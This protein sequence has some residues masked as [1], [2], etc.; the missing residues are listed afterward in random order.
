MVLRPASDVSRRINAERLLLIAW[1]RAILLQFAHPMIAAAVAEH[2]SFR[3]STTAAAARLRHTVHAMLAL[4]FGSDAEREAALEAIQAIHRRVYGTMPHAS[5]LFPAG[6]RYSAEDTKLLIWVHATLVE[7]MVLVYEQLI[8]PLT[9]A[10]RDGYCDEA[11]DVAVALGASA[12][13]VPRS[14]PAVQQYLGR[15]YVSGEIAVGE[16]ASA[17]AGAL[18]CPFRH[19]FGRQVVTPLVSLIAAGLLPENVRLQ[20]GFVWNRHRARRFTQV[21]IIMRALRRILPRRVALWR[22]GRRSDCMTLGHGYS[23]AAR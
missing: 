7:S 18:L 5:G 9:A 8:G 13:T 14:W 10:E 11:A 17:L 1:L 15:G 2:S 3:G 4:T 19:P 20:Y 12:S 21:M 22:P 16:N 23:A 6:T